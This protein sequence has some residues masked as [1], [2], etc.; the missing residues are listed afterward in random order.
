ML[1]EVFDSEFDK[2]LF[3]MESR[4]DRMKKRFIGL[5]KKSNGFFTEIDFI[6]GGPFATARQK[7]LARAIEDGAVAKSEKSS[8]LT[9]TA[10]FAS[11]SP[12]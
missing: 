6:G 2:K 8:R 11:Y 9:P 10:A 5:H 4:S 1:A 12:K 7:W 3:T